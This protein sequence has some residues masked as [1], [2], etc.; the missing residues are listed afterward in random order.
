M[1]NDITA[2]VTHINGGTVA[3]GGTFKLAIGYPNDDTRNSGAQPLYTISLSYRALS[4]DME[5]ALS[6]LPGI[7]QVT[8]I[9]LP[10][11]AESMCTWSVSYVP[12]TIRAYSLSAVS[13]GLI[14]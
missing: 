11:T 10:C 4:S 3:I 13:D 2:T 14:G 8:C 6:L 9:A 7:S 1:P 5:S 12:I